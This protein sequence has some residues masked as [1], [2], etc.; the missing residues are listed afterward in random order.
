MKGFS[1]KETRD[2][3]ERP[4][5][6]LTDRVEKSPDHA[7]RVRTGL[8]FGRRHRSRA[9]TT[10]R[11]SIGRRCHRG[12]FGASR[13]A[14]QR[15]RTQ[16]DK[17]HQGHHNPTLSE[18]RHCFHISHPSLSPTIKCDP[19]VQ[20]SHHSIFVKSLL[21]IAPPKFFMRLNTSSQGGNLAP[22]LRR[23]QFPTFPK[24]HL[25][26]LRFLRCFR[27]IKTQLINSYRTGFPDLTFRFLDCV[28]HDTISRCQFLE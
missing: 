11:P 27:L 17:A 18:S 23:E 24:T 20:N 2:D 22:E 4:Y 10:S 7:P 1:L 26:R 5:Q 28:H 13:T 9:V 8:V 14:R 21:D 25:I 16:A 15:N 6:D 3:F 12:G 19:L